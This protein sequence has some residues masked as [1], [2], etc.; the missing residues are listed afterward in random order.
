MVL[1]FA[2]LSGSIFYY[3]LNRVPVSLVLLILF[4]GISL[5]L[6]IGVTKNIITHS[7]QFYTQ[8][9]S[10]I[11]IIST[12][13]NKIFVGRF[14]W[15]L[16]LIAIAGVSILSYA[17]IGFFHNTLSNEIPF[18][19]ALSVTL[20]ILSYLLVFR[21]MSR[22][23]R[24][25]RDYRFWVTSGIALYYLLAQVALFVEWSSF[26][27]TQIWWLH[28]VGFIISMVC[29]TASLVFW[30]RYKDVILDISERFLLPNWLFKKLLYFFEDMPE[31]V[32]GHL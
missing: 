6:E 29:F 9:G 14:Y 20:C 26:G 3:A 12:I 32:P 25:A 17:V 28:K 27:L 30:H 2:F 31:Q 23:K 13:L 16:S 18:D 22:V 11:I 10:D 15:R 4:L 7:Q 8:L 1:L 24:F 19:V 5:S 21:I